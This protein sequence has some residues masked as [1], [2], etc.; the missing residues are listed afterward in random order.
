MKKTVILS[1]FIIFLFLAAFTPQNAAAVDNVEASIDVVDSTGY[2]SLMLFLKN[3]NFN[4]A[5]LALERGV[6]VNIK[7]RDGKTALII[8]AE[9]ASGPDIR[10]N[11]ERLRL[12]DMILKKVKN[13]DERDSYGNTALILVS[14]SGD[15]EGVKIL[16]E[17]GADVNAMNYAGTNALLESP[18][19]ETAYYLVKTG[20][21]IDQDVGILSPAT[22]KK[23]FCIK[24]IEIIKLILDEKIDEIKEFDEKTVSEFFSVDNTLNSIKALIYIATK[25]KIKP[26]KIH[27]LLFGKAKI[28][29]PEFMKLILEAGTRELVDY[30]KTKGFKLEFRHQDF[31]EVDIA[32]RA[33]NDDLVSMFLKD[34]KAF[35]RKSVDARLLEAFRTAR[36]STAKTISNSF[37]TIEAKL[38]SLTISEFAQFTDLNGIEMILKIVAAPE[39]ARIISDAFGHLLDLRKQYEAVWLMKTLPGIEGGSRDSEGVPLF[40]AAC[41]A[42]NIELAGLV[43][44]KGVDVNITD[45][46]RRTALYYACVNGDLETI[47]FLAAVGADFNLTSY[48]ERLEPVILAA[49]A[50]HIEVVKYFLKKGRSIDCKSQFGMTPLLAALAGKHSEC[51]KTLIEMGADINEKEF[52]TALKLAVENEDVEIIK[53]L[54]E[55][56]ADLNSVQHGKVPLHM[57]I[58]QEN[59][60]LIKYFV[61][62]GA[63]IDIIDFSGLG[64]LHVAAR[65]GNVAIMKSLVELGAKIDLVSQSGSTPLF[66]A[67]ENGKIE[68]AKYLISLGLNIKTLGNFTREAVNFAF[69]NNCDDMAIAICKS[70][71]DEDL[72]FITAIE[73]RK[74]DIAVK[75]IK[76]RKAFNATV[77]GESIIVRAAR[78]GALDIVKFLVE[79]K[80]DINAVGKNGTTALLCAAGNGDIPMI[81]YLIK[82]GADPNAKDFER[83][84]AI[85]YAAGNG[86]IE[87]LN[88]FKDLGQSVSYKN[89]HN[90]TPLIAAAINKKFDLVK[91]LI[92]L[93]AELNG[94]YHVSEETRGNVLNF[95]VRER[96]FEVVKMLVDKKM[97]LTDMAASQAL[98]YSLSSSR[99][100]DI[101]MLLIK[102]GVNVNKIGWRE[103]S[104]LYN[105]VINENYN[106]LGELIEHGIKI[107]P[108]TE[109]GRQIIAAAS[110]IN[111]NVK[112]RLTELVKKPETD[113]ALVKECELTR[114]IANNNL[115][116]AASLLDEGCDIN[117]RDDNYNTPLI[118]A[119][120]AGN[121][122]MVKLLLEKGASPNL[123]GA[124]DQRPLTLAI[125]KH[126]LKMVEL[127]VKNG[128]DINYSDHYNELPLV[129]STD[130]FYHDIFH[131]LISKSAEVNICSSCNR[132][133][134]IAAC[135]SIHNNEIYIKT[136][137]AKGA[138]INAR[139][140]SGD[141]ALDI[142]SLNCRAKDINLI[143]PNFDKS[144]IKL[145]KNAMD[146]I[147]LNAAISRE[148]TEEVLAL[149]KDGANVNCVT[150]F[151]VT[152]LM[153]TPNL[154]NLDMIDLL[155]DNGAD[156]LT[157]TGKSIFDFYHVN[158]SNIEMG[159]FFFK[160]VSKFPETFDESASSD[161]ST[162]EE[163][164][165]AVEAGVKFKRETTTSNSWLYTW[166][167]RQN[168]DNALEL[169]KHLPDEAINKNGSAS[170]ERLC[171]LKIEKNN[172]EK[173]KAV[174]D[175]LISRGISLDTRNVAGNTALHLAAYSEQTEIMMHLLDRGANPRLLNNKKESPLSICL[176][177][178]ADQTVVARMLDVCT[179]RDITQK[180]LSTG[181]NELKVKDINAD[182]L[183]TVIADNSPLDQ[184][185]IINQFL[186]ASDKRD[187]ELMKSLLAKIEAIDTCLTYNP[188]AV[189]IDFNDTEEIYILAKKRKK[190]WAGKDYYLEALEAAMKSKTA[191]C[192]LFIE[193]FHKKTKM[194]DETLRQAEIVSYIIKAFENKKYDV[195]VRL[196]NI[197]KGGNL[198][199]NSPSLP[200]CANRGVALELVRTLLKNGASPDSTDEFNVYALTRAIENRNFEMMNM[201][202]DKGA[203]LR[204]YVGITA[205]Q[206]AVKEGLTQTVAFLI[207]KGADVN[208]IPARNETYLGIAVKR[209]ELKM[210]ELLI[211]NG[212]YFDKDSTEG[213]VLLTAASSLKPELEKLLNK[214]GKADILRKIKAAK[215]LN[216][217]IES[218]EV[219]GALELIETLEDL[220]VMNETGK[221]HLLYAIELHENIIADMLIKKGADLNLQDIAQQTPLIAAVRY[222]NILMVNELIA[223]GAKID[224]ADFNGKT[225]LILAAEFA[226]EDCA[227][228]LLKNGANVSCR[229]YSGK[230]ALDCAKRAGA[231]KIEKMIESI[232]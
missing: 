91:Y 108:Y 171:L 212:A 35:Y 129:I 23:L 142:L 98:I 145:N 69:K 102:N 136:L 79:G 150:N 9:N 205:M 191:T 156:T 123:S 154:R 132:T 43:H 29:D 159:N 176:S 24:N 53:M 6:D 84:C 73:S 188:A 71:G 114:H 204:S 213:K 122:D 116:A 160:L 15:S 48:L 120:N 224:I 190:G 183:K 185:T 203:D 223:G 195:V 194:S 229:D 11:V 50:G 187:R 130:D 230:T 126:D 105:A 133:P 81:K 13:I 211:E 55:K 88:I 90:L 61:E 172:I 201:L 42:G 181:E 78:A 168:F 97:D 22:L 87:A 86:S 103:Y 92:S 217:L 16:I 166:I 72:L 32:I 220:N 200:R 138:D 82:N 56:G 30:L 148:S 58:S 99:N 125:Q 109:S 162:P 225:P 228:T 74:T 144:K 36:I 226:Y 31:D 20:A 75:M 89:W 231:K 222:K 111:I 49:R 180:T 119:I 128:A 54:I 18:T 147:K 39:R 3:N 57:A 135:G 70:A 66:V 221:T 124:Y 199:Y 60:A 40:I 112:N 47:N 34:K 107:N 118:N 209:G 158:R 5:M 127:L 197:L 232:K 134:L 170:I 85:V 106:I 28:D 51:A 218:G 59:P 175:K 131:Y 80:S 161:L 83:S 193:L 186:T 77:K 64:V 27:S 215:R 196:E 8:L 33:G 143:Y 157:P 164:K 2:T 149:I 219:K 139:N 63:R 216:T 189:F 37:D 45:F 206:C 177:K 46:E 151:N 41:A 163:I 4:N 121:F 21:T 227:E 10:N 152:P 93:N 173:A 110:K 104:A 14:R 153:T 146:F 210:A 17:Y 65:T 26:D 96:N 113:R 141:T 137:L 178:K 101:A 52:G 7:G 100:D 95:A 182:A 214:G 94:Y 167:Y 44:K 68:A 202:I 62:N 208:A 169:L 207:K 140:F 19:V 179:K 174:I 76:E 25:K 192:D 12:F 115:S 184:A 38:A 117:F 155:I 165:R 198:R 67:L 1:L